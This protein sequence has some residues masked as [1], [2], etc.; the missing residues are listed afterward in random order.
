MNDKII[1][2]INKYELKSKTSG[3]WSEDDICHDI[4]YRHLKNF[5]K[6]LWTLTKYYKNVDI[7]IMKESSIFVKK[8]LPVLKINKKALSN[9]MITFCKTIQFS[10]LSDEKTDEVTVESIDIGVGQNPQYTIFILL[11][12]DIPFSDF[13]LLIEDD[14]DREKIAKKLNI[15]YESAKQ[16]VEEN[17]INTD[18]YQ[19]PHKRIN[20][21]R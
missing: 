10:D 19:I 16:Y 17:N 6:E 4:F 21:Y 15:M 8:T 20:R 5:V 9:Y 11:T 12:C 14:K 3:T 1:K 13:W 7:D 2:L 18:D